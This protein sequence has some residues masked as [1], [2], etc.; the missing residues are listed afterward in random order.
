MEQN[1]FKSK[2]NSIKAFREFVYENFSDN[3]L[4][5]ENKFE[6]SGESDKE[7][8]PKRNEKCLRRLSRFINTEPNFDKIGCEDEKNPIIDEELQ[9]DFDNK[10]KPIK[11]DIKDHQKEKNR[12]FDD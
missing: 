12:Q 3:S 6:S 9:T 2:K 8:V 7:E 10:S 11:K 1:V 5:D 4:V